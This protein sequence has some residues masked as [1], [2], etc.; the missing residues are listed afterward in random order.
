MKT[1]RELSH[2]RWQRMADL[3]SQHAIVSAKK[4]NNE[5]KKKYLRHFVSENA[6]V[7]LLQYMG[8]MVG[9]L[10]PQSSIAW[11]ATGSACAYIFLRGFCILP[12]IWLGSFLAYFF[13][14]SPLSLALMSATLY[15][16]QAICLVILCHRFTGPMLIFYR[17]NIF[18]RFLVI[19]GAITGITS[20]LLCYFYAFS[21]LLWLQWW[22]A[23][24]NGLLVFACALAT[25]D[26]YFTNVYTYQIKQKKTLIWGAPFFAI[27]ILT[28]VLL[29][30]QTTLLALPIVILVIGVSYY[31]G[32][33]GAISGI[34]LTGF[35]L[36]LGACIDTTVFQRAENA[37]FLGM[38]LFITTTLGL[39][40]GIKKHY[41]SPLI[42]KR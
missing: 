18:L 42:L 33:N 11:C 24:W 30:S 39:W 34:F 38:F 14:K 27:F 40:L 2:Y 28:L 12:G 22:V 41:N 35:L 26:A 5:F 17:E 6:L 9:M 10:V 29:F 20:F 32:W 37:F 23:N 3:V 36:L 16:L 8:L 19:S 13:A 31:W 1:I 7:F 21:V 4:L 25:L 15:S